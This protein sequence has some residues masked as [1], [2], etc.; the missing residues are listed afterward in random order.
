MIFCTL[1]TRKKCTQVFGDSTIKYVQDVYKETK[2]L[3]GLLSLFKF[4]LSPKRLFYAK[5]IALQFYYYW[6]IMCLCNFVKEHFHK[7]S[8]KFLKSIQE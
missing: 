7:I 6:H 2:F 5:K 1:T 3:N 4:S 8:K